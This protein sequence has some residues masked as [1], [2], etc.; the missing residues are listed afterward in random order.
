[1]EHTVDCKTV[2]Q[3]RID[4]EKGKK[5]FFVDLFQKL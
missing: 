4:W 3:Y 5:M 2:N 1:M